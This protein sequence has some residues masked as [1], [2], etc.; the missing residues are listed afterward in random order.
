MRLPP[1]TQPLVEVTQHIYIIAYKEQT[2]QL[3][4]YLFREGLSVKLLRQS[5][6]PEQADFSPSYLCLLNH[7]RAWQDIVDTQQI[8]LVVEADFIP[9][10]GFGQ[11]PLSFPIKDPRVGIAWLYTCAPQIYSVSDAGFAE[12][13]S[14]SMVAYILTPKAAQALIELSEQVRANIGPCNYST[15]DSS[16]DSFLRERSFKNYVPFRN[17]GEHG[18][19]PNLEHKQFGLSKVHR[20]DV[21][22]GS[23]AFTPIYAQGK[24]Q[25]WG[26]LSDRL[27]ARIKGIGRLVLGKYLR[28]AICLESSYSLRLLKWAIGRH[29]T[30][31]I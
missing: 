30:L 22:Y 16:I 15:W 1:Q 3:E 2:D 12:G 9:V 26:L 25:N 21:L 13:Y 27:Q 24:Q 11:L 8:G 23:L 10:Q 17:Y 31:R 7:K 20:A 18:G 5:P 6:N 4:S 14:T 19:I 28:P 29:L